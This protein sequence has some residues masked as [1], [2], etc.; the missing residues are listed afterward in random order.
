MQSVC[1]AHQAGAGVSRALLRGVRDN[2]VLRRIRDGA[3]A[4]VVDGCEGVYDPGV[5][6][7]CLEGKRGG[8]A[9]LGRLPETI[10]CLL[11]FLSAL[12][13]VCIEGMDLATVLPQGGS[14]AGEGD[15]YSNAND[16]KCQ[17]QYGT[18]GEEPVS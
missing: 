14:S 8:T 9:L 7:A 4:V 2:V 17:D 15:G 10:F 11:Y 12:Y 3:L 5:C 6:A 16:Q 1:L 13:Q 18:D